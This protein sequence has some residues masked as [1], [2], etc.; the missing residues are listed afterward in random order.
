MQAV[1]NELAEQLRRSV[2][3]DDPQVRLLY[4]SPHYGDEDQVRTQAMLQRRTSPAAI[5]YVLAQGVT[6]WNTAGVIPANPEIG[7]HARICVP[8][9][10]R[11]ELLGLLLVVDADETM[12]TNE[13]A[14]ISAVG[15]ELAALMLGEHEASADPE[16][17][18]REA[19]VED[20]FDREAAVRRGAV[21]TLAGLVDARSFEHVRVLELAIRGGRDSSPSHV[22]AAL[23]HAVDARDSSLSVATVLSVVRDRSAAVLLG[24]RQPIGD[25][26]ADRYAERLI[27][28]VREIAAGRFD[29]VAGVGSGM[30]GLEQAWSAG[31]Q[32]RLACRAADDVL[33]GRVVNWVDLGPQALLLQIPVGELEPEILPDEIQR[34]LAVDKDGRLIETLRVFLDRA[35]NMPATADALHIHRTTLY[36]RLDRIATLARLD[37]D[38]GATRLALH[39]SLRVMD[40]MASQARRSSYK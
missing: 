30:A 2:V 34:L 19:A 22:N 17:Q 7:M 37:L 3:V 39:L 16:L 1:I 38:D 21:R 32:A 9:R 23:R 8:I 10:W 24:S 12:T 15:N 29:C 20:L 40:A 25:A 36:Y 6:S 13:L 35:G 18:A 5:G 11:A 26:L 4:A 33:P 27:H 28:A 14:T 31:R